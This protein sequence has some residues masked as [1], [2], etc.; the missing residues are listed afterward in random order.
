MLENDGS[1]TKP[2]SVETEIVDGRGVVVAS[3][4]SPLTSFPRQS[5]TVRRRLAVRDPARW[6]VD[7]PSLY[8][9]RVVLRDRD[10]VEVDSDETTF[11]IRSLQ[12]DAARGLRINGEVV[13]LRGAC[14]HHD[15]GVIG[16]ATIA[17]AD[18]RRVEILKASGSTPS[19]ART[20]QPA[21]RSS[22]RATVSGWS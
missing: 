19:A 18:E 6:S 20:I 4:V 15:N 1:M 17:R 7:T 3:E 5:A 2:T 8:T 16:A 14:I 13:N 22:T 12:L 10:D 21:R 9:C 11:G